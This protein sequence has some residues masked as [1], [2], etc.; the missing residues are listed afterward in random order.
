MTIQDDGATPTGTLPEDFTRR[1]HLGRPQP[2]RT[3][4]EVAPVLKERAKV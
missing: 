2:A 4:V 3:A 1:L